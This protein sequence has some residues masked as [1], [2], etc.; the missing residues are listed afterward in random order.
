VRLLAAVDVLDGHAVRL[1]RGDFDEVRSFG[2]APEVLD[3]LVGEGADAFHLVDLGRARD[4]DGGSGVGAL[5]ERL[6]GLGAFVEVGGGLRSVGATREVLDAGASRVVV[7]TSLVD[8]D[9]AIASFV[10]AHP[11]RFVAALDFRHSEHGAIVAIDGWR[12]S[13]GITLNDALARVLELGI[14]EVLI[15]AVARDGMG[16]GPELERY[17]E[18][19]DTYPVKVIASGG[20]GTLEDLDQL[21]ALRGVLGYLDKV[22]VGTALLERRFS[23]AEAQAR[24]AR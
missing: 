22:V 24:C 10:R 14:E 20:V 1:R 5:I 6:V 15:T 4:P 3:W 2:P 17:Q 21:A 16:G 9:A 18:V 12:R 19:I 8:G 7:G 23:V 11:E 13:S